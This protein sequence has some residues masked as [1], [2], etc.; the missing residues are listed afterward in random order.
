M[1]SNTA[2][3][4]PQDA[5][6]GGVAAEQAAA[7]LKDL[8]VDFDEAIQAVKNAMTKAPVV[9]GWSAFGDDQVEKME[10]DKRHAATL[11][12]NIQGG[13]EEGARTDLESAEQFSPIIPINY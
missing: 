9:E 10:E 8:P 3:V 2:G 6:A 1:T 4:N 7:L 13:A 5:H 11:A 12:G